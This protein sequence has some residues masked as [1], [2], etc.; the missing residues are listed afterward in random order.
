MTKLIVALRN[1]PN[2]PNISN[3]CQ[4]SILM[5]SVLI[6]ELTVIVSYY[7]IKR[8]IFIT[9]TE[10]VYCSVRAEYLKLFTL[11]PLFKGFIVLKRS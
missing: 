9:E 10:S 2:A 7:N 11:F 8:L 1:S 5:C 3:L 6:L 4:Q